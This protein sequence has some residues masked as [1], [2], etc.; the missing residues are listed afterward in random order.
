VAT[1]RLS[2]EI[3]KYLAAIPQQIP[4]KGFNHS[5][6]HTCLISDNQAASCLAPILI[7]KQ[8][9]Q[10]KGRHNFLSKMGSPGYY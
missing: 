10:L 4:T 5:Q 8:T 2:L 6:N 7:V 9:S 3:Q 1:N